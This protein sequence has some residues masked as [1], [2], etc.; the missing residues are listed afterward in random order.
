MEMKIRESC[1]QTGTFIY[2]PGI[3]VTKQDFHLQNGSLGLQSGFSGYYLPNPDILLR[4]LL[5]LD[6]KIY[7][8]MPRYATKVHKTLYRDKS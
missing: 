7:E 2:K 6:D 5:N 4:F 3:S 8:L 1:L